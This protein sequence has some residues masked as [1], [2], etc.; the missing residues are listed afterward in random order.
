MSVLA[1]LLGGL[2]ELFSSGGY[3]D[4]VGR[5]AVYIDGQWEEGPLHFG[6]TKIIWDERI[7]FSR[8][9]GWVEDITDD[10]E[11]WQIAPNLVVLHFRRPED[12]LLLA[13]HHGDLEHVRK[14]L[15][16]PEKG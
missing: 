11:A 15:T 6:D 3:D 5:G 4:R 16:L 12:V 13:V 14:V 10:D 8:E 2:A 7:I 1:E 9:E